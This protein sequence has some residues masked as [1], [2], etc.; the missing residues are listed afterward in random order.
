V[1]DPATDDD[2]D[3]VGGVNFVTTYWLNI[4]DP[5]SGN[6]PM[7]SPWD[8]GRALWADGGIQANLTGCDTA[9]AA[10]PGQITICYTPDADSTVQN[11]FLIAKDNV[12]TPNTFYTK[13]ISAD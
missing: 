9:S 3:T 6:R 8:G 7:S 2:N 13:V 4:H 12:A 11:I 5:V 1:I 10:N